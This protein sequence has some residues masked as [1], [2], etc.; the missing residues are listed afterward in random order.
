MACSDYAEVINL[1]IHRRGDW[2]QGV[3][4]IGPILVDGATPGTILDR[5]KMQFRKRDGSVYTLD[6]EAGNSPDAPISITDEA[7]WEATILPVTTFLPT[8][9]TW[10]WDMEFYS[11][12]FPDKITFYKGAIEVIQ[13]HTL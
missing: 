13:D 1:P 2:W 3:T 9:G 4:S 7:T 5:I 6:S 11:S 8:S 10:E 12:T